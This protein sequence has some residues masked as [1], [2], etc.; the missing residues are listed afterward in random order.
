LS[1]IL[2]NLRDLGVE[3]LGSFKNRIISSENMNNL[4]SSFSICNPSVYF[5]CFIALAKNSSTNIEKESEHPVIPDLRGNNFS[6]Q[7]SLI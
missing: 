6:F 3:S 4:T 2:S 7:F 1:K 5:S